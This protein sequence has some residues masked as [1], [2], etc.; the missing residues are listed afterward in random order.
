MVM[1]SNIKDN[2]QVE[3]QYN[4]GQNNSCAAKIPHVCCAILAFG[5]SVGTDETTWVTAGTAG[6]RE[7]SCKSPARSCP[8]TGSIPTVNS[9]GCT[10]STLGGDSKYM[11]SS[12]AGDKRTFT[13]GCGIITDVTGEGTTT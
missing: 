3:T 10:I 7:I 8:K 9:V 11:N 2:R 12:I 6:A 5:S 1:V 4:M 13:T